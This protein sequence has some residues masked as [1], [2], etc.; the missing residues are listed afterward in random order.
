MAVT[1]PSSPGFWPIVGLPSRA[2][3]I[4]TASF[5]I[6]AH[7]KQQDYKSTSVARKI[8]VVRSLIKF[9]VAEKEITR[10]PLTALEPSRPPL[11]L[12]KSLTVDEL[13]RLLAAPDIRDDLR[14]AR[15]GDA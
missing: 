6:S 3:L 14:P 4:P 13:A 9:L 12:P 15:Q 2:I 10:S 8:S 11:R 5:R 1:L 7:L